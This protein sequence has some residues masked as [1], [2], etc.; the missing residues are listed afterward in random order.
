MKNKLTRRQSQFLTQFLDIYQELDRPVHYVMIAERLHLGKVTV[1]EM[2]R[3]LEE[4]GLVCSEYNLDSGTRGPGRPIILFQPTAEARRVIQQLTGDPADLDHW[5]V[6]EEQILQKLVEGKADDYEELVKD[7]LLRIT[8]RR[9]PLIFIAE[10]ITVIIL[11]L[12]TVM[13]A[14]QVRSML[15][16]LL[17]SG[18]PAKI[19][20]S[21]LG[22][23]GLA[24]SA[25]EHINHR[26]ATILLAQLGKYEELLVQMSADNQC[27]LSEF[28]YEVVQIISA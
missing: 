22:G 14:Q 8:E 9:S 16:R 3:L 11:I 23:I 13:N 21:A 1:Y 17:R 26:T 12:E 18:L 6:A 15:E 28:A 7:L 25:M 5:Q 20:L 19:S 27:R 24:I 4:K 10:V 2:L